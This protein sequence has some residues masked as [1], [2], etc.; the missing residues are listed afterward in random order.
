MLNIKGFCLTILVIVSIHFNASASNP[1]L[2]D[3]KKIKYTYLD[4]ALEKIAEDIKKQ[5]DYE[6]NTPGQLDIYGLEAFGLTN[7]K[8]NYDDDVIV[9]YI[10]LRQVDKPDTHG[11]KLTYEE[12][13]LKVE[14]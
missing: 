7:L 2:E 1:I 8:F 13:K 10:I 9:L 12:Y 14:A 4:Y 5:I 11:H 3:L 6:N